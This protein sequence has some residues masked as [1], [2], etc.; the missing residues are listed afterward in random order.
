MLS[1]IA[2]HI[3]MVARWFDST[4]DGYNLNHY[5]MDI[6][7]KVIERLEY[8]GVFYSEQTEDLMDKAMG[9]LANK[10]DIPQGRFEV[11]LAM[12][13]GG[14]STYK[15]AFKYVGA[16]GLWVCISPMASFKTIRERLMVIDCIEETMRKRFFANNTRD[17]LKS[18]I[19]KSSE[20]IT[21]DF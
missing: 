18:V 13:E 20:L 19:D 7:N 21:N 11:L 15:E 9:I 14:Y 5:N 12:H 3:G 4:S 6:V 2:Q 17:L 8:E 10:L 16:N 1:L